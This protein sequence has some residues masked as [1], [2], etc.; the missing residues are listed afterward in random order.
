MTILLNANMYP[1]SV[2]WLF[3][4]GYSVTEQWFL[5]LPLQQ[6]SKRRSFDFLI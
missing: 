6:T 1:G 4:F 2:D 3:E 5:L